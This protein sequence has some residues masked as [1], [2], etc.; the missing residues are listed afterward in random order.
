MRLPRAALLATAFVLPAA[1]LRRPQ[2][3]ARCIPRI[4]RVVAD[5]E[6]AEAFYRDALG[7]R[8][9]VRERTD[10]Q[11]LAALGVPDA[12]AQESVMQ[13]GKQ[14]VALVRFAAPGRRYPPDSRSD[15]LWF[16]HLAVVVG[17]MDAAYRHLARQGGW[18]PITSGGPQLLPPANGGVRAFKFRDPD[19]HPLEL[20]WF[21]PGQGR[22]VWHDGASG[23]PF[24]G[25]D[26]SALAVASARRSLRFYRAL[27]LHVSDRSFNQGPAQARLDGL[28]GARVRV[29]GLRPGA[30]ASPGLELLAYRPPGRPAATASPRDLVT[31]WV[32]LA[33]DGRPAAHPAR[34]AIRMVTGSSWSITAT[35]SVRPREAPSHASTREDAARSR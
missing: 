32:T 24:L 25:I 3:P 8:P 17:D 1:W 34:S 14:T 16:Q 27:G 33:L 29:T 10:P 13:L 15:D 5:L 19:G 23:S 7:F 30:E 11:V 28:S 4:S 2:A 26:H 12:D 18:Q 35:R 9:V 6:R 22:A 31:D 20:I 21:P